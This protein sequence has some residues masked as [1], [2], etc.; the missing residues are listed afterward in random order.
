MFKQ[1]CLLPHTGDTGTMADM[2]LK[3]FGGIISAVDPR[4]VKT[5]DGRVYLTDGQNFEASDGTITKRNGYTKVNTTS[6]GN[7]IL[8]IKAIYGT[9]RGTTDWTGGQMKI[10]GE[11]IVCAGYNIITGKF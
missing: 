7:A 9:E 11:L 5:D 2:V 4:D 10:T 1:F 3:D 6:A 8:G